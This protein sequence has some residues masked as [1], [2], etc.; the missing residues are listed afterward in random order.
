[1]TYGFLDLRRTDFLLIG[2][3]SVE[4][5]VE[6]TLSLIVFVIIV[7][8]VFIVMV[9]ITA[10]P[11]LVLRWLDIH[12]L[13]RP[14]DNFVQFTAIQPHTPALWTKVDFHALAFGHLQRY[15]T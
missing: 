4:Q 2:S 15:I 11:F 8:V 10:F 5:I 14:F 7:I 9:I 1:M 6:E 12:L 3:L 13:S